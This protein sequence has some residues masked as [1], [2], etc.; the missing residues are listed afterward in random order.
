VRQRPELSLMPPGS[1]VDS[2]PSMEP[3]AHVSRDDSCATAD[4]PRLVH[5][6]L[7]DA[8]AS[9]VPGEVPFGVVTVTSTVPLL[10]GGSAARAGSTAGTPTPAAFASR[11]AE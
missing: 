6:A 7:R 11:V 4:S 9:R 10:A 5:D 2:Q 3:R 1:Q 8:V